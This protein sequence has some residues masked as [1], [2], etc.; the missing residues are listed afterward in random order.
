MIIKLKKVFTPNATSNLLATSSLKILKKKKSDVLDLGCGTGFV[1][2]T[3]AKNLKIKNNYYFS[4]ISKKAVLLC[5]KNAGKNNIKIEA[6]HGVLYKPW[7]NKKFDLIIESVSA[8]AKKVAD[9]SPWYTNNIPCACG[10]DGTILVAQILKQSKKYLKK[11]GKLIFPIVSLSN[12][13]KIL[14]IAKKYFKTVKLMDSKEWPLPK[15]MYSKSSLLEKL[16]KE[17]LIGFKR[18][19]GLIL[20]TSDIYI[21]Y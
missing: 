11:N 16:K 19:F 12:K 21:A 8:I 4:D 9:I 14:K 1:G 13:K 10:Q 3:I 18:K 6:K 15:S 5:K 17:G 7:N 2:L 20:Y